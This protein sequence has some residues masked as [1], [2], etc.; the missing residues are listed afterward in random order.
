MDAPLLQKELEFFSCWSE[1]VVSHCSHHPPLSVSSDTFYVSL[2]WLILLAKYTQLVEGR[3]IARNLFRLVPFDH[4]AHNSHLH[5]THLTP[6]QTQKLCTMDKDGQRTPLWTRDSFPT[7]LCPRISRPRHRT[8][9]TCPSRHSPSLPASLISWCRRQ[10]W[11]G[12]H[13]LCQCPARP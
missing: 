1:P 4:P 12:P 2:N 6:K 7:F 8:Q 9:P 13:R 10:Y 5:S 11:T 3:G